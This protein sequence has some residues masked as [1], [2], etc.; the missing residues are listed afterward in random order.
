MTDTI[1]CP[2]CGHW[3]NG[4]KERCENCH[5]PLGERVPT[6]ARKFPGAAPPG[7]ASN[8][9][10]PVSG[11][12][13]AEPVIIRR[14]R[15][16]NPRSAD[17][18]VVLQLWLVFGTIG[19]A[20]LIW[21]AV[22]ANVERANKPVEGSTQAQQDRAN[23]LF[24]TLARDSN[25]VDTHRQLGDILYDTANWPEAIVHYRAAI[26]RDSSQTTAIVD[27]GVCYFNLGEPDE[28]ERHF[29]IAL[30]RDPAQNV[31][32]FN[33]GIISETRD[34]SEQALQWY[35]RAL[36]GGP[37]EQMKDVLHQR[38]A[39]LMQKLGREAPPLPAGR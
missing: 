22:Q 10:D 3:N 5:H 31:A 23:A 11:P 26:R 14:R 37:P 33:M 36:Q 12:A 30:A 24:E 8:A 32:L 18:Q 38:I 29:L 17:S 7:T 9:P 20:V 19:V 1:R 4:A 28:A 25:N 27:L 13:A 39:A 16:R 2:D 34:Q 15:G 21:V 35:H 6:A